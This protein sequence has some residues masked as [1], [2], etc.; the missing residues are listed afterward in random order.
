MEETNNAAEKQTGPHC[1]LAVWPY[2][3]VFLFVCA[4]DQRDAGKM[5]EIIGEMLFLLRCCYCTPQ[6]LCSLCCQWDNLTKVFNLL[7]FCPMSNLLL[8]SKAER[9]VVLSVRML[10]LGGI[11]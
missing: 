7:F 11:G 6:L 8:S 9:S 2:L 3:H 1:A 5:R 4:A 10:K